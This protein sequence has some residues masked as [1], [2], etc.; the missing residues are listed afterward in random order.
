VHEHL[1]AVD[2]DADVALTRGGLLT[3]VED[4]LQLGPHALADIVLEEVVEGALF[5]AASEDEDLLLERYAGVRVASLGRLH[6]Y[7]LPLEEVVAVAFELQLALVEGVEGLLPAT[8]P[9]VASKDV[10]FAI[11][12]AGGVAVPSLRQSSLRP[13]LQ[14]LQVAHVRAPWLF[15]QGGRPDELRPGAAVRVRAKA[16]WRQL[17][18]VISSILSKQGRIRGLETIGG[19]L[20]RSTA[21]RDVRGFIFVLFL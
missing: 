2:Q 7:F 6:L 17:A 18:N 15:L 5:G 11:H 4:G 14:L 8:G 21:Q 3:L 16:V 12:Y 9:V 13:L 19:I 1:V 10:N 20:V